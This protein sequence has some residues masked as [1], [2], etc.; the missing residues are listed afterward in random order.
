MNTY[1]IELHSTGLQYTA[2]MSIERICLKTYQ[3]TLSVTLKNPVVSYL[4]FARDLIFEKL[5]SPLTTS[6]YFC[7]VLRGAY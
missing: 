4:I 6:R 7:E 1:F 2:G 5:A 3:V